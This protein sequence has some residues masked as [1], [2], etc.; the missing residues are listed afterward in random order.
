MGAQI[1]CIT[2]GLLLLVAGG[3]MIGLLADTILAD[4]TVK[5]FDDVMAAP[6]PGAR[7]YALNNRETRLTNARLAELEKTTV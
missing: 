2:A 7:R 6:A 1:A 3:V 5:T 4:Y